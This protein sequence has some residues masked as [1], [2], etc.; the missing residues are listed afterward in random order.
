MMLG[1]IKVNKS[2]MVKLQNKAFQRNE[3][4]RMKASS[5]PKILK[6]IEKWSKELDRANSSIDEVKEEMKDIL[7]VC[8]DII[9]KE[10]KNGYRK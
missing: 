5:I 3:E 2:L 10:E 7:R 1:P 4:V 6:Q 9:K 8:K